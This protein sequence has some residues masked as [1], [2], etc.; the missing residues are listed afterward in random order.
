[1]EG[2]AQGQG[3]RKG[4]EKTFFFALNFVVTGLGVIGM[5][6]NPD[7]LNDP[8]NRHHLDM[9]SFDNCLLALLHNV[10]VIPDISAFRSQD[11]VTT[12]PF[13]RTQHNM[14]KRN[15]TFHDP[16]WIYSR[17]FTQTGQRNSQT[18]SILGVSFVEEGRHRC[19][20]SDIR[21]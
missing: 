17:T 14:V 10:W 6:L 5:V 7:K 1:M 19:R 18:R 2:L 12:T 3:E 11:Y 21:V 9:N 20:P 15:Q 8:S 16:I 4:K 13:L